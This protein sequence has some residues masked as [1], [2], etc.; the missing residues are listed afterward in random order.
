MSIL[1][2][3]PFAAVVFLLL[4]PTAAS[5]AAPEPAALPSPEAIRA[6][7]DSIYATTAPQPRLAHRGELA[8]RLERLQIQQADALIAM[9]HP[10]EK[11][12]RG[13]LLTDGR[14]VEHGI[15][16]NTQTV[17]ALAILARTLPD[18]GTTRTRHYRDISL[19][20]LRFILPTH[21]AG[22]MLCS[23][24]K[25]WHSQWQSAHWAHSAGRAAWLLWDD[26]DPELRWLAARMVCDE[27]DRF[28]H[29]PPPA[30]VTIDTKAEENAWNST[31]IALAA[32]MFPR[33]PNARAWQDTAKRWALSAFV[34][35]A[36]LEQ[37]PVVDGRPLRDLVQGATIF[38]DYT[39][40]NHRR[41]HPDYM[42]TYNLRLILQWL[43]EWAG[44]PM[45]ESLSFNARPTYAVLKTL[46]FP[47]GGWV[48][49]NGQDW[50]LRRNA[51]WLE[52]HME[53]AVLFGDPEAARLARLLIP[54]M[55]KMAA[56]R[57]EGTINLSTETW[58]PSTHAQVAEHMAHS[59][60]LL[61][62]QGEGA[63]PVAEEELWRRLS[64]RH[65]FTHG[66]FAL[67]RTPRSVSTFSWGSQVMGMVLPLDQDL[68]L[69]PYERGLIGSVTA[70]G[71]KG[72]PVQV[73]RAEVGGE[74]NRL[75]VCGVL[76]RAGGAVEQRFAFVALPDGRTVYAD[77]LRQ[78][79]P[80]LGLRVR[81]G[82]LHVL[83]DA[84]WPLH[85]G[86]RTLDWAGGTRVFGPVSQNDEKGEAVPVRMTSPWFNLDGRLGIICLA[87]GGGQ[88]YI[89]TRKPTRHRI[90]QPFHLNAPAEGVLP[91]ETVVVFYPGLSR[92]ETRS[93]ADRCR[94]EREGDKR[95]VVL[96]DG[97]RILWDRN[98]GRVTV[99]R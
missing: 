42:T 18:D 61:L 96:E 17:S 45:P 16:P 32:N 27:A 4:L 24:G 23:N 12:P 22:G 47:D 62:A 70:Q 90:E 46:T 58:F 97:T 36:D 52:T 74:P 44:N 35:A 60:L 75:T 64:G 40:E 25:P 98:G 55:E 79:S 77:A 15:R 72:D 26:L 28:V 82:T 34:R 67:L 1:R 91:E 38:D 37:N 33:H 48:Y 39:L 71:V 88:E 43:Y 83:N 87:A 6:D 11:D 66:E 8:A 86:T 13:L 89:P 50:H 78:T 49:A 31:V 85:D 65:V 84:D 30:Q 29:T 59:Y 51:E 93:R 9:L 95:T 56:R 53:H 69:A 76:E 41:V 2:P 54:V 73:R 81:G 92:E 19:R 10:W 63:A 21:R 68:L 99:S 3:I 94:L 20:M 5:S 7:L 80:T 57:P 14:S